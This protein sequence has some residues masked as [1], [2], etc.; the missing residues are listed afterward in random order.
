MCNMYNKIAGFKDIYDT[1]RNVFALK[2]YYFLCKN[3]SQP[4]PKGINSA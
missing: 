2:T 4:L 3:L 1:F